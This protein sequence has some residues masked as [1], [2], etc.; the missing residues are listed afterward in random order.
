[1]SQV[2]GPGSSGPT[3][4]EVH[5]MMRPSLLA[6]ALLAA[7]PLVLTPISQARQVWVD[8]RY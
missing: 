4:S 3:Y 7:T 2:Y 5:P 8:V 1:M 6:A